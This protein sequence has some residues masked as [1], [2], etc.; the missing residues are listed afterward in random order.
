MNKYIRKNVMI[1]QSIFF[2]VQHSVSIS[3]IAFIFPTTHFPYCVGWWMLFLLFFYVFK[4]I[5]HVIEQVVTHIRLL[6]LNI[7]DY[8][9]ANGKLGILL[10]LFFSK[11]ENCYTWE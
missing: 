1:H 4:V 3:D 10:G 2:L 11:N 8:R 6:P 9:Y 7:V 5:L